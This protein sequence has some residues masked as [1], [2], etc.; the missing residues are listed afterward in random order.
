MDAISSSLELLKF[1]MHAQPSCMV[2]P[3][4]AELGRSTTQKYI[5]GTR[6]GASG[7]D[8]CRLSCYTQATISVP[9][10]ARIPVT[11]FCMSILP[12]FCPTQFVRLPPRVPYPTCQFAPTLSSI[13][14]PSLSLSLI[15]YVSLPLP[16]LSDPSSI[17][18]SSQPNAIAIPQ[19]LHR[20]DVPHVQR[21]VVQTDGPKDV[22]LTPGK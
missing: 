21:H 11:Q 8:L 5:T 19:S 9:A 4:W 13:S 3:M 10:A 14:V 1:G 20:Q 2:P 6:P 16:L 17:P 18:V 7:C 12:G 15:P 22:R